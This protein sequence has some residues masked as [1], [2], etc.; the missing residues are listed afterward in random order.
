MVEGMALVATPALIR[1]FSPQLGRGVAM[2]FWTMG[3][4]LGSLV[5]TEVSSRT[6]GS[7]PDWQY[8]FRVAGVVGL[9][10]WAI[11][12]VGSAS[13]RHGSAIS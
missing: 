4:V 6:L 2:G 11:T 5:V 12:L 9:I 3:P 1:D 7:H 8:Q 10:V 13:C